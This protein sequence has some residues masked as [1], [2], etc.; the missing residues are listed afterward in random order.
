MKT[1]R[2]LLIVVSLA[3]VAATGWAGGRQE[4]GIQGPPYDVQT[5]MRI[6][7]SEQLYQQGYLQREVD[8]NG[9]GLSDESGQR[10]YQGTL[11]DFQDENGDGLDD[12]TGTVL[13]LGLRNRLVDRNGDGMVDGTSEPVGQ[14]V[15]RVRT[16]AQL[17]YEQEL[18]DGEQVRTQ[19]QTR[20][21]S[22]ISTGS[23]TGL[24]GT[25]ERG[26]G[27]NARGK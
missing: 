8:Q 18:G 5:V 15:N 22:Q 2:I 13:P 11:R 1:A 26:G 25:P 19:T 23:Q 7:A 21:Q 12:S 24:G 9:D 6:L 10:I 3:A 27:D 17:R 20:Q 14:Y 16:E 4:A